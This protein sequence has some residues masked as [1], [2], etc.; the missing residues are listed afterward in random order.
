MQGAAP[1]RLPVALRQQLLR[2]VFI[3]LKVPLLLD[4]LGVQGCQGVALAGL[5]ARTGGTSM[6]LVDPVTHSGLPGV[7]VAVLT[8]LAQ[9]PHF[10]A[11]AVWD[12]CWGE[13]TMLGGV[14]LHC[15]L[16]RDLS[17]GGLPCAPQPPSSTARCLSTLPSTLA[18]HKGGMLGGQE[19]RRSAVR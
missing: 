14:S 10:A 4:G 12:V 8:V 7:L 6:L 15:Q 9:P 2:L 16:G 13:I 3:A 11:G 17:Q 18:A 19:L 1:V 5:P